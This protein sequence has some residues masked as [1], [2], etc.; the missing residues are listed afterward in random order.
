MSLSNS[1]TKVKATLTS[2]EQQSPVSV[3]DST[4][5]QEDSPS[6]VKKISYAFEGMD[7][8]LHYCSPPTYSRM[9][10][11]VERNMMTNNNYVA[12]CYMTRIEFSWYR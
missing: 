8:I 11:T 9:L 3:L 2:S 6:P 5:Y 4:F 12:F 1:V 10:L 7:L